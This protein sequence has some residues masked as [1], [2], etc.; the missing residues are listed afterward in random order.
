MAGLHQACRH[1]RHLLP[2]EHQS[3]VVDVGEVKIANL[4]LTTTETWK[5]IVPE[6]SGFQKS[7]A[8]HTTLQ[9]TLPLRTVWRGTSHEMVIWAKSESLPDR[10]RGKLCAAA[11][12]DG[13]RC[14]A[15]RRCVH[16]PA[17]LKDLNL[18]DLKGEPTPQT[19][20]PKPEPLHLK[21][22]TLHPKPEA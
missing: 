9:N 19:M 18:K 4:A 11:E 20:H 10:V 16:G 1:E 3:E 14:M 21:P 17:N 22:K 8:F 12:E 2:L 7:N 6:G 5:W 15:G 13:R